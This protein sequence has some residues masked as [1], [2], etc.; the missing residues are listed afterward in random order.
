MEME[1]ENNGSA[2]GMDMSAMTPTGVG[3]KSGEGLPYAPE[4][5]PEPGDV[6]GWRTGKRVAQNGH[7]LDRYLY[8]PIRLSRSENPGSGRKRV[9]FPSKLAVERYLKSNFPGTDIDA[10]F[11]MFSWKFP[12]TPSMPINGQ[13]P[14]FMYTHSFEVYVSSFSH[15]V[16]LHHYAIRFLIYH[17]LQ[18]S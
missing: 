3:E 4:N 2:T 5:W 8:L 11:A 6:W 7:F 13:L 15:Y 14:F 12:S 9:C 17:C 1:A 18:V 10:F 16:I